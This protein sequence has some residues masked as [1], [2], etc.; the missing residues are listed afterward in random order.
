LQ[1]SVQVFGENSIE[2]MPIFFVLADGNLELGK[3][4]RA[5]AFLV[6]AH[7]TLMKHQPSVTETN[8]E[9]EV[10]QEVLAGLRS[11]L[12]RSFGRLYTAAGNYQDALKELTQNIYLESLDK[13]PEHQSLAGSYYLMGNIF[14][15]D[16]RQE[17]A[18]S[19]YQQVSEVW[20][21]FLEDYGEEPSAVQIDKV[22]LE[23]ACEVLRK[24]ID[25]VYELRGEESEAGAE[26]RKVLDELFEF[27]NKK[28]KE[29]YKMSR[30]EE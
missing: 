24:I 16:S 2:L 22:E 1:E 11:R 5:E 17:E 7:W 8:K 6:G 13:G 29:A 21:K 12:H 26:I 23:E 15:Q 25:F 18:L 30:D 3:R 10:P 9:V 14:A 28:E 27:I 19:F 4:K 20:K